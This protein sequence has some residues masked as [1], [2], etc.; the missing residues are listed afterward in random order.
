MAATSTCNP[1]V[2][3]T[4]TV[5]TRQD[6][7][8]PHSRD[9]GWFYLQY[10]AYSITAFMDMQCLFRRCLGSPKLQHS[11]YGTHTFHLSL[12]IHSIYLKHETNHT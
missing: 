4:G 2:V 11:V 5:E 6:M 10:I 1:R 3:S 9:T 7:E 8:V 12:I